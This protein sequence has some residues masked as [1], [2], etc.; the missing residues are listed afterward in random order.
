VNVPARP[1]DALRTLLA[2]QRLTCAGQSA[3]ALDESA[4]QRLTCA[5][6]PSRAP[7]LRDTANGCTLEVVRSVPIFLSRPAQVYAVSRLPSAGPIP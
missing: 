4:W 5:V 7:K 1:V 3:V 6:G 2:W